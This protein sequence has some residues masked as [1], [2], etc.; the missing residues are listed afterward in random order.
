MT[1]PTLRLEDWRPTKDTLHLCSQILGRI[2]LATTPPRNHW[3]NVALSVDV[4]GLTT[5]R[6]HHRDTTFEISLDF[7]DHALVVLASDGRTKRFALA[8]GVTVAD[9]YERL[10]LALAELGVDVEI[11]EE[12]FDVPMTTPFPKDVEHQAWDSD[13]LH[14]FWRVLDWSDLVFEEFSGWYNGKTSPVQLF[15]HNLD[16]AVTRFSGR[17]SEPNAADLITR[18]AHSHELITFGFWAGDDDIGEAAYYAYT[19]PEP[20]GLREQPLPVGAWVSS[21][22]GSLA[23]LPY[24]TVRSSRDPRTALLAFCQSAY[25]AGA[26]LAGW[27]RA[28]FASTWSPTPG[29]LEELRAS[30]AADARPRARAA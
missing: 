12:P 3:W 14:R 5:G 22:D 24:E 26:T 1:L 11:S 13:A 15:W 4:R 29:Q 27:D 17:P 7:A 23:V 18:D 2:R 30:A 20:E 16:L 25:E 21:G 6:L 28:G 8:N 10:H 19:H 9:F